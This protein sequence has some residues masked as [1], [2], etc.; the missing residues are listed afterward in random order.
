MIIVLACNYKVGQT[1]H[2][3]CLALQRMGHTVIPVTPTPDAPEEWI[4]VDPQV[5]AVS[6]VNG[7]NPKPDAFFYVEGSVGAP[8]LPRRIDELSIP[9]A[10]WLYDNYLNFRWHKELCALFDHA[11]FAQLNRVQL[12]R[13]YGRNNVEWLPFAADEE[14]HRD[15]G[16]AR[17]I[18][19]GY[20]GTITPQKQKY[21]AQFEKS[22]MKVVTNERYYSYD[23]I[24]RFYSRCKLV[25]N[26]LARRDLNVRSFEAPC[27][28]ALVVNQGWIDEGARMIFPEGQAAMY[29][30]FDDAPQICRRLLDDD[31]ERKRMA[32]NAR[33]TVLSG[34]TYRHRMEKVIEALGKGASNGRIAR[35]GDFAAP[36]AEGLICGHRDFRMRERAAGKLFGGI[37]RSPLRA[38]ASLSK[39]LLW[40][41]YEKAEKTVWSFGKA[42]V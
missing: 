25:Y 7:L 10:C 5:D 34:H 16:V 19:I 29:H 36:L 33:K 39:Y 1:G 17:D 21:F 28:G 11:F 24:G 35:S 15:F 2:F 23:E 3:S 38:A 9:A 31:A 8:F 22:G 14:F 18:D 41:V 40:R 12:A 13:S 4:K 6:L 37:A 42:P 27:A 20:L 26:I 32:E 30:N